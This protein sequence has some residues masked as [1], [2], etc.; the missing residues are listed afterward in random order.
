M[1]AIISI[2]QP[3]SYSHF[4][5]MKKKNFTSINSEHV[6]DP[7]VSGHLV[8]GVLMVAVLYDNGGTVHWKPILVRNPAFACCSVHSPIKLIGCSMLQKK[9]VPS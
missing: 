5:E 3:K 1:Y 8:A 6:L 9:Y 4:D 7:P 2:S